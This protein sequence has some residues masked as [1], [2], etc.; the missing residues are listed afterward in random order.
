MQWTDFSKRLVATTVA[1]SLLVVLF[2]FASTL[3]GAWLLFLTVAALVVVAIMEYSIFA[4]KKEA[5]ISIPILIAG[6]CFLLLSFFTA[7]FSPLWP[8]VLTLFALMAHHLQNPKGSLNDLAASFFA[9]FYIAA[10]MGMLLSILFHA[11][12]FQLGM[13]LILYLLFV[14]KGTDVGAYLGGKI[15]GKRKLIPKVSPGKTI[16]GTLCGIL[17]TVL[18]S[19]CFM[20]FQI[21]PLSSGSWLWF[22]I[23]FAIVSQFGDLVESLLKRDVGMKDSNV[24]PGF[25]GVLDMIDSLLCTTPLLYLMQ[26]LLL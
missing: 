11:K 25:G 19:F 22:G 9:L 12:T 5:Y 17:L 16:E 26:G 4:K 2:C 10:P 3:I 18:I 24:L 7:S 8:I 20:A 15:F 23:L 13:S 6:S 1:S 21:L 14:T